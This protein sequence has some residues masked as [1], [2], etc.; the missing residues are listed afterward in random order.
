M[1]YIYDSKGFR[2][3]QYET[4]GQ[5]VNALLFSKLVKKPATP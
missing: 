2:F 3:V 5:R 4:G 1:E